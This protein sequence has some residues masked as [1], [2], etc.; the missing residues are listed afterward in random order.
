V[1]SL[2]K[3]QH[4]QTSLNSSKTDQED[5]CGSALMRGQQA[6]RP[7]QYRFRSG[8][9]KDPLVGPRPLWC[10]CA[11]S[12]GVFFILKTNMCCFGLWAVEDFMTIGTLYFKESYH[13]SVPSHMRPNE[14]WTCPDDGAARA[15][16]P[17]CQ[18]SSCRSVRRGK[19]GD[20][21]S[22]RRS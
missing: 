17:G 10:R 3:A 9:T 20:R 12:F 16:A 11:F 13:N 22:Q 4:S 5:P 1:V 15:Q 6:H 8:N 18:R 7:V 19:G 21:C 14:F 2:T